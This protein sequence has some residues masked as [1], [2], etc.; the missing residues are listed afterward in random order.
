[1]PVFN[2]LGFLEVYQQLPLVQ[3]QA[4]VVIVLTS[5]V[6]DRDLERLQH[7]PVAGVFDKPLTKEKLQRLLA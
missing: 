5:A 4:I 3:R 2:G 1:M 7:L 6:L